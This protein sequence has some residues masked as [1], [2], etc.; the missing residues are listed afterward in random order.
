MPNGILSSGSFDVPLVSIVIPIF[1]CGRY[2]RTAIESVLS[3][4]LQDFEVIVIDDGSTDNSRDVVRSFSDRRIRLIEEYENAGPS[5]AR[6][7]GIDAA[8]GQWIAI[9]DGD[10]WY[11]PQRL[12]TLLEIAISEQ[13]DAIA[14]DL[15][16]FYEGQKEAS[17]TWV[18]EY[19]IKLPD[20]CLLSPLDLVNNEIGVIK[21]IFKR[22]LFYKE[23]HRYNEARVYGED[24]LLYLDILLGGT[25]FIFVKR[26]MYYL[27]RGDTGSLTTDRLKLVERV[28]ELRQSL[29]NRADVK[30]RPGLVD[31]LVKNIYELSILKRYHS[32][33]APMRVGNYAAGVKLLINDRQIWH[34]IIKQ[35]LNMIG[36]KFRRI[37]FRFVNNQ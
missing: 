5:R 3:Q 23:G 9:L 28:I 24:F 19:A 10:D 31:A 29:L 16:I 35:V 2:I 4:T 12:K 33:V 18:R 26:P 22:S 27:R 30:D 14:D 36:R 17:T 25:N 21:A 8:K 11:D 32:F 37:E 34:A 15:Y 7:I 1:N 13:V 6:N 20:R